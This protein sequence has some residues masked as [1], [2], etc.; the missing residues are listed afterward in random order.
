[1]SMEDELSEYVMPWGKHKGTRIEEV[2]LQYLMWAYFEAD[3]PG[4]ELKRLIRKR[5]LRLFEAVPE[6]DLDRERQRCDVEISKARDEA[7][8]RD[9]VTEVYR[10]LSLEFHPDKDNGSTVSHAAF[11]AV[12]RFYDEVM[13]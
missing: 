8:R 2:P 13:S 9:K 4:A 6:T 3:R 11:H 12:Q 10:K 7:R 5:V 1:M